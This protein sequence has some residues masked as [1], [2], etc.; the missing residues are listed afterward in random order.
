MKQKEIAPLVSL[1][2]AAA[3]LAAFAAI[4][5]ELA[6]GNLGGLDRALLLTLREPGHP[7]SPLGPPWLE[8]V[9]DD[10]TGLGST[11]LI[12]LL[13]VAALGFLALKRLW[14]DALLVLFS[15]GGGTALNYALKELVHRD[16]PRFAPAEVAETFTYSFPSGHAFLSAAAFLTLGLLLA[17]T[18]ESAALKAYMLGVAIALTILVGMSRLYLSVHWP[19][20]VLA[21]WCAGAGWAMLCRSAADWL[22]SRSNAAP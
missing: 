15:I 13:T 2:I 16:R 21:G 19:T 7:A 5:V 9:A 1:S 8:I 12:T 22:R 6:Q 10:V 4:A 11:A 14:G 18:Q 20:D 17:R 3:L